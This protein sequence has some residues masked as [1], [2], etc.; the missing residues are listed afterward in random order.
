MAEVVALHRLLVER[1]RHQGVDASL[2]QFLRGPAQRFHGRRLTRRHLLHFA[3]GH[4][5]HLAAACFVARDDRIQRGFF[6]AGQQFAV[7]FGRAGRAVDHRC[8]QLGHARVGQRFENHFPAYAV[9]IALGDAYL[10]FL[11]GHVVCFIITKI[12]RKKRIAK[13]IGRFLAG[14]LAG[15]ADF[16]GRIL[17]GTRSVV[18]LALRR[19]RRAGG[20]RRTAVGAG[21]R[22]LAFSLPSDPRR[23][24]RRRNSAHTMPVAIATLSDSEPWRSAG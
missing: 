11:F 3:A 23:Q 24:R 17:P 19:L 15:R 9:R 16:R 12:V 7:V 20:C 4:Q 1:R 2:F 22:C 5:I 13:F 18:P 6:H 21:S 14:N 10:E 8:A